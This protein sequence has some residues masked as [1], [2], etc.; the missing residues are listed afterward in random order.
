MA[1]VIGIK[2]GNKSGPT[3]FCVAET[4]DRPDGGDRNV[5][6]VIRYL[7]RSS[8]GSSFPEVAR[9]TAELAAGVEREGTACS[10]IYVDATGLGMPVVELIAQALPY[11]AGVTAVYFNYGDR[12]AEDDTAWRVEVMLGKAYL[13]CRLKTLLQAKRLHLPRTPEAEELAKE[14]LDYEIQIAEDANERYGAFRVGTRDELVT[15]LGLA[16][17]RDPSLPGIF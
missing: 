13:V 6:Y 3:A 11:N 7:K 2:I 17:Q 14:L 12:R 5:H 16:V 10:N 9:R 1:V 4:Q 15:A 8:I